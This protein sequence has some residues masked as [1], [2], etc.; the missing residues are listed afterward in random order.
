MKTKYHIIIMLVACFAFLSAKAQAQRLSLD[1]VV[2]KVSANP[3]LLAFDAKASAQD[4]YATGA[5]SL[6]APK[7]SAGQ[8]QVPYQFSPNGGSFMIQAEQMFTNPAKLKAKEEYMK[9]QSKV[10]TAEKDYL[11]NQL[12]AQA[13][14][15]YYE[16]V[17]LEKK[18]DQ[19]RN[20]QSLL[21]YMLK[22][23]NIRLT[24]GKEKLSNIYKAKADL[25]ELDN[26]RD[27]LNSEISQKNIMLNT[28]MNRDKQAAFSV[29][30]AIVLNNYESTLT[31]TAT[32]ANA[33][34]DIKSINRNIELQALNAKVEYSKR[35]PD[36]G[37]QAAH[38]LSYGGYA[39]QYILMAS[40]TIPIVPWA[41]KEYKANLKGIRY[42]VEE[43]QQ[44][45]MDVLNQAQG[46]LASIR[47]D[48]VSKKKQIGNYQQNIIPALQN[49][50]KTALL[51]YDQ[52]TGD[53]PSVL[54]VIKDL[55]TS[56]MNALD[57]LQ[58]LLTLQVA[59][60][61]EN[62]ITALSPNNQNK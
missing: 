50:Y 44:R 30:T 7:I 45:K 57:R 35:K 25:F 10:T 17:V 40:V 26:T 52:N 43:L 23:A 47:T 16:R 61:R 3:A 58:E 8:Y 62:E 31:D 28:L 46:Q 36:F 22:D 24:Y 11:K 12:I 18:L 32:L 19:L 38:M 60:E 4:A 53:L 15:Y 29:D 5:K 20:T 6:D 37:I 21:E 9:G 49:G 1:S 42:E 2:A 13:K 54:I 41:S 56:R 34:S 39:N 59:Y 48:M 55:Q 14:Q 27:Q 33:R 51:A